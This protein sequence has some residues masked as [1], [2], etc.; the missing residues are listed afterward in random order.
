MAVPTPKT[1]VAA[2]FVDA[3]EANLEWRDVSNFLLNPPHTYA[4]HT[5]SSALTDNA[6]EVISL[7]GELYDSHGA[8]STVTNSSRLVA[9]E[10]GLYT[11]HCQVRT[12]DLAG[13]ICQFQVRMNAA[14]SDT[15]GTRLFLQSQNGA[16]GG[17]VT[18]LGRSVDYPLDS[19]DYIELFI[20]V[21]TGANPNANLGSG[22]DATFLSF[23]WVSKQ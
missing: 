19:G 1:W 21:N 6:W 22:A 13:T 14:G 2:E 5:A 3:A 11:I 10:I 7:G 17:Q 12:S 8:H 23:R 15:G 9:P 18:E 16:G 20:L 4:N